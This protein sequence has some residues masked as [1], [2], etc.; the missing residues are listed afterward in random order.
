[1]QRLL[2]AG[3]SVAFAIAAGVGPTDAADK[4]VLAFV[5][6]GASD[7]WKIAEAGMKKAQG[8]LPSYELQFKYPEQAAAAVQQRVMDDLVAAGAAGIMVSAVDPK[9]QTEHLNKVASQTVLFTTD[10][11]APKSKRV[12]YI[13]SSNTDLGKEAGKLMVK[14]LP[15]GGKCVGFVGLPGADNARERIE[16]VKETLKGS[17]VELVDVRGDEIDQTRAKRNVEDI[18]AAM[19]DVS[20]LVGFYSYNTPRIYEVLKEAGKL[21]KI[22]IIGF[23]E[24]PI[25]LG[26]VKEGSIVG[27]VVQQPFEWGYQGMKLMANYIGG[28]KSGIPANG[29]IIVPGKVIEKA[30]VDEFMASM[31]QMLKK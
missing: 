6:N 23:D 15:N 16:G 22:K 12:A 18:L 24:D 19:P 27:T 11:D 17:K 10:S 26:G 2:V 20:C 30:N 21:G 28:N 5:V 4:K 13:G 31:K 29:I 9:N 8:E 7:F 25:T 14:A 1:M 3:V